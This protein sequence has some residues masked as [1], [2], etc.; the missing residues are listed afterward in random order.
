M[1][2]AHIGW[3]VFG[4]VISTVGCGDQVLVGKQSPGGIHSG[5]SPGT[6]P[7]NQRPTTP[8]ASAQPIFSP[9]PPSCPS[10]SS[11]Q[12][13][14]TPTILNLAYSPDG[15]TIA[16]GFRAPQPN[17]SVWNDAH[18]TVLR[19]I[20]GQAGETW[21]VAFSPN[22]RILATAGLATPAGLTDPANPASGNSPDTAMVKLWDVDSGNLLRGIPAR[23][24]YA[25]GLGFS[26]DGTLLATSGHST[27]IEI[28]RVSDGVLLTSIPY[29]TA[30]HA[31]RFSQ[32]GARLL[33]AGSD[34][35]A[36]IWQA[37]DGV[38]LLTLAGHLGEV[39]DAVFSPDGLEIA[40]AGD[41]H[42]VRLWDAQ[43]GAPQE[44]LSD[45][46]APVSRVRWV[47][48]N[49]LVSNDWSGT[50]ILWTRD[51]SGAFTSSCSLSTHQQSLGMDV[52]P[53]GTKLVASGGGGMGLGF[54]IFSL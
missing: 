6:A 18:S 16:A 17:V 28:W 33:T 31:A 45:H 15:Q 22:G 30:V 9:L 27:T 47:D 37:S 44:T 53:D 25:M 40:T 54:W 20:A 21:G 24:G 11:G 41:D 38:K 10:S 4:A 29:L 3:F 26:Q 52:S 14:P 43:T 48:Q 5:S 39:N 46:S 51:S 32:D 42:T 7:V 13:V 35:V 50:V 49:R 19:D 12:F 36:T 1:K 2:V 34:G 8:R 23:C